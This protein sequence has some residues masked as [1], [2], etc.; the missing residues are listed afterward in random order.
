M[1][2]QSAEKAT[3]AKSTESPSESKDKRKERVV[4]ANGQQQEQVMG[5][6]L[7]ISLG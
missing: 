5:K 2:L 7:L 3:I 4:N 1:R 6:C